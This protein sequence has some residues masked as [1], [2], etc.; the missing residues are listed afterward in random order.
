MTQ[1]PRLEDGMSSDQSTRRLLWG[2]GTPRTMRAHWALHELS[3]A[4]QT[5]RIGSRTGETS[6]P[7]FAALNARGKIPVL[8]DGEFVITESA[9]II[10]YLSDAY[11]DE[12]SSLVPS[13]RLDRARWLEWCFF[14]MTELDATSL[15][16]IRRH[17]D[18]RAVYGDAPA[19]VQ[20]AQ[21]Y[22][23]KQLEWASR[24][25]SSAASYLV[26]E[27][28]TTADILL[29]TCLAWADAQRF[30]L[31]DGCTAYLRRTTQRQAY[32]SAHAANHPTVLQSSAVGG[33]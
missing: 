14:I 18:L 7:E 11:S 1:R 29:T 3:L 4:Y 33:E 8:Q 6:A 19:A 9:A 21:A 30:P 27:Q 5:R 16:V 22:F 17:R 26:G 20:S 23:I 2:V 10:T 12:R 25:L 31:N 13:G 28:F 32:R 15:Y 24:W